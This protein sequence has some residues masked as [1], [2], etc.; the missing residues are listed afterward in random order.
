MLRVRT[1]R[2]KLAVQASGQAAVSCFV[3]RVHL[4]ERRG[5]TPGKYIG[6]V[7]LR[8]LGSRD[9]PPE[10]GSPVALYA[11]NYVI[12]AELT[13]PS[14][15]HR[16]RYHAITTTASSARIGVLPF[17]SAVYSTAGPDD[18]RRST[19]FHLAVSQALHLIM[20]R[21]PCRP[22]SQ[23][24]FDWH[25]WQVAGT[26]DQTIGEMANRGAKLR[27]ALDVA[28]KSCNAGG[29]LMSVE[30]RDRTREKK[31]EPWKLSLRER[32]LAQRYLT[33]SLACGLPAIALVR[34][35]EFATSQGS[36]RGDQRCFGT[37]AR[38]LATGDAPAALTP[39]NGRRSPETMGR[40]R[41]DYAEL[42]GRVVLRDTL[43][44]GPYDD[45]A[46]QTFFDASELAYKPEA[47]LPSSSSDSQ[48]QSDVGPK[49]FD[50][51][52]PSP[53]AFRET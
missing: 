5:D 18:L 13:I 9:T 35:G 33:D 50:D 41:E 11:F 36:I 23:I 7:S 52:R 34:A 10:P 53:N 12:D 6:F 44:R 16:P 24:E 25:L 48:N 20:A 4:F 37:A 47:E 46:I 1:W 29:F 26:G 39:G 38:G 19:C 17:R 8:P 27:E 45:Q 3:V 32:R 31:D 22:V 51:A 30:P 21:F 15:I 43:V 40:G 42:T 28:R 49:N 14:H 2:D